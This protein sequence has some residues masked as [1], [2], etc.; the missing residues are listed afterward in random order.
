[1]YI[2]MTPYGNG[3]C[4]R[5]YTASHAVE[6]YTTSMAPKTFNRESEVEGHAKQRFVSAFCL[7]R[8]FFK[9]NFAVAMQE[10][11]GW[12]S[13]ARVACPLI[14]IVWVIRICVCMRKN[15][16]L[17]LALMFSYSQ[18]YALPRFRS[19][20]HSANDKN[21]R[22]SEYY[23]WN[24]IREYHWTRCDRAVVQVRICVRLS[25]RRC[26]LGIEMNGGSW[27]HSC[28]TTTVLGIICCSST[29]R[30][31]RCNV[32]R[33]LFRICQVRNAMRRS[34][35]YRRTIAFCFECVGTLSAA[36]ILHA[37]RL[38]IK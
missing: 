23:G 28:A 6:R 37:C 1:M 36:A 19:K 35:W 26:G 30:G 32:W 13:A 18:R 11:T 20:N 27:W 38:S 10:Y 22:C 33:R 3:F 5:V 25:I 34:L 7:Y 24:K 17:N 16:A 9:T 2:R 14:G 8:P 21:R 12:L 31:K 15:S 4:V 29:L